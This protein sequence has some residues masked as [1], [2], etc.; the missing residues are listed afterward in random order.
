MSTPA[1]ELPIGSATAGPVAPGL[2]A[3]VSAINPTLGSAISLL[4]GQ[5][6]TGSALGNFGLIAVGSI[7]I[8]GALLISQKQTVIQVASKAGEAAT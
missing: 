1:S 8:L 5:A 3:A 7:L 2:G 6:G 4:T